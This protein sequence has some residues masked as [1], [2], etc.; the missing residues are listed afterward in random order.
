MPILGVATVPI[1]LD[2]NTSVSAVAF[3]VDSLP[4]RTDLIPGQTFLQ[5]Y[6]CAIQFGLKFLFFVICHGHQ[7]FKIS[8]PYA[9]TAC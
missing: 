6:R 4:S 3:V 1:K 8:R 5:T 2:S 7:V 9:E